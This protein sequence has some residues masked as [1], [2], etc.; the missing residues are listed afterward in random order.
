MIVYKLYKYPQLE[1][2]QVEYFNSLLEVI[3]QSNYLS[4]SIDEIIITDDIDGEVNRYSGNRFR[5]P[6]LTRNREY[7]GVAKTVEFE[8]KNKIF[9]DVI[10]VN[11]Y[12]KYGSQVFLEQLLRVRAEDIIS[13][14]YN[15][16]KTYTVN[17]LL[18]EIV[19]MYF[20]QWAA[21]VIGDTMSKMFD[22]ERENLHTDVKMFVDAFKRN[23]RKL[24]YQYQD[25]MSLDNF[26]IGA[27]TEVDFFIRRCFDV[28]F[29][30]GSFANLQEFSEIVPS[31]LS[32]IETQTQNLL[33]K[34][35]ISF[36]I[37]NQRVLE[38]LNKC[39]IDIP[40]ENRMNIKIVETPKKLFKNNIVDTEPRIVAF[41]DILGFSAIIDEYDSNKTSN[42][43]NELHDTLEMAI[44]ISIENMI[45]PKSQT[46][47]KEL[48]EYRMF[49]DCICLSLPY[50]EFGRDF[51]VQFHSLS[52]IVRAYQI[53]MMQ[54]GFFVRGGISMGSFYADKNM[55]FSGG[56]VSAYKLEQTAVYPVIAID[57]TVLE[58]LKKNFAENAKGLFYENTML[59]TEIEP[60]KI[61]LNP[62]DFIDNAA[63]N[64]EYLQST[65]DNL[66]KSNETDKSN[67]YSGMLTSLLKMTNS[68]T[69]PIFEHAKSQ[70]KPEYLNDVKAT[71]LEKIEKQLRK[72]NETHLQKGTEDKDPKETKKI[73]A[74]LEHLKMLTEWSMGKPDV[75]HFK[76]YQ[77]S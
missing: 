20:S 8:G 23:M 50:I 66:I 63:K 54:K 19:R 45:D 72:H 10:N 31:L 71:I 67:P 40:N 24:H 21:D 38:I 25:D 59:F 56:L 70:V 47:I 65:M 74:K 30:K 3:R 53:A 34:E 52:A 68:L 36:T 7:V 44:K 58:R 26:W 27:V 73:I 51:H 55:I 28:K 43:L 48:L 13:L 42:I 9:F 32:E 4:P 64:F 2:L 49:S 46:D 62:F 60:E 22:F 6:N 76:Y 35:E 57:K 15:V 33:K 29:D 18:P 61:F 77:F 14:N 17:T 37:M 39:S 16:P 75:T 69:Q 1:E 41:I 11:G 5:Q 12:V